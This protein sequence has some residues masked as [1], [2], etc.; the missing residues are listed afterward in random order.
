MLRLFEDRGDAGRQLAQ[1][2][3]SYA[4]RSGVIVLGLPRG[5]VPVAFEI[6][7]TLGLPLDVFTVHKLGVPGHE[8]L[9]M[10][11]VATG[12]LCVMNEDI[13][14][15]FGVSVETVAARVAAAE[16]DVRL[17]EARYRGERPPLE[18]RG[19]TVILVDDGIATGATVRAAIGAL[20][21]QDAARVVVAVP[22]V[23]FDRLHAIERV[24]DE[25]LVLETP[26]RFYSVGAWYRNFPQVTDAEVHA[27]LE[28][29]AGELPGEVRLAARQRQ[30]HA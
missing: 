26:V 5:G 7:A 18:V 28:Q 13:V 15:A 30:Q 12:D 24:A 21:V 6:A 19:S 11:A 25:V 9:A 27:L 8:E 16:R 2:L 10:G 3:T 22:V 23:A 1:E 17:C 14:R 4:A 29:A 20:H